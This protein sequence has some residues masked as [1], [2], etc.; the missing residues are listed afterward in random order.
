[1]SSPGSPAL[2]ELHRLDRSS[3]DFHDQL[4]NVLFE[5]VYVQCVPNLRGD[6]VV[7]LVDYLD[8][9]CRRI[10]LPHPPLNPA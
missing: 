7:W 2:Q 3:P 4:C 8:A 10:A 9:V 6:D 1:M 5:E